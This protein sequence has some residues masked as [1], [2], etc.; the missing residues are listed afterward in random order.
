MEPVTPSSTSR[1][2]SGRST[3]G[4]CAVASSSDRQPLDQHPQ[5]PQ[6]Q[7]PV[8]PVDALDRSEGRRAAAGQDHRGTPRRSQLLDRCGPATLRWPPRVRARRRTG[9]PRPC[10]ARWRAPAGEAPP[11][12]AAACLPPATGCPAPTPGRMAPPTKDPVS[13]TTSMVVAVPQST[14]MTGAPQVSRAVHAPSSR[15]EPDPLRVREGHRQGDGGGVRD[16]QAV[17]P[18]SLTSARIAEVQAGTTLTS[19]TSRRVPDG[20]PQGLPG[21]GVSWASG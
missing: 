11:S 5:A 14:T 4:R 20:R 9:W 19:A 13:S 7:V 15:S 21:R 10:R 3:C 6:Q 2:S 1:P 17:A 18:R 12:A 16:P 8:D